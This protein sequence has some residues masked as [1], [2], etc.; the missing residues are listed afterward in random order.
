MQNPRLL[1]RA[2][3]KRRIHQNPPL[4][5]ALIRLSSSFHHI[6]L[7]DTSPHLT[8]PRI[9]SPIL[10]READ[11]RHPAHLSRL[12]GRPPRLPLYRAVHRHDSVLVR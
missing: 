1:G 3:R 12:C 4:S 5:T 11:P 6:S 8:E 10:S 2:Y 7:S 9:E